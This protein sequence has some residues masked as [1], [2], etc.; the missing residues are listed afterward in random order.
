V[1]NLLSQPAKRR[2]LLHLVNYNA[3][4]TLT[5][6]SIEAACRLPQLSAANRVTV[7]SPD[8]DKE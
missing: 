1:A 6:Q 7:Y 8:F 3:K 2:V 5:V 4:S